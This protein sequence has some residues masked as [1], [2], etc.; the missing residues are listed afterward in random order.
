MPQ[1]L[2]EAAFERARVAGVRMGRW[3]KGT[4]PFFVNET[5]LRR[6]VE[7]YVKLFLS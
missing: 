7:E 6:P 3:E 4:I 2:A 5:L 1:T